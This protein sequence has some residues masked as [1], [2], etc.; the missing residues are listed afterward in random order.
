MRGA[1]RRVAKTCCFRQEVRRS[2]NGFLAIEIQIDHVADAHDD[3]DVLPAA[4]EVFGSILGGDAQCLPRVYC[5]PFFPVSNRNNG[6]AP[7]DEVDCGI[8]RRHDAH[9][10]LFEGRVGRAG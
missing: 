3:A 4:V 9:P 5:W 2:G 10:R 8:E 6:E 7:G 1:F